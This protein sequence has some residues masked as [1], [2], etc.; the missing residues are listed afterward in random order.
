MTLAIPDIYVNICEQLLYWSDLIWS[1]GNSSSQI[2]K[3]LNLYTAGDEE[4]IP[5]N[6]IK[7]VQKHLS[8]Q[9]KSE[10]A[11]TTLLMDTK[12]AFAFT[13]PYIPTDVKLQSVTIPPILVKK[14]LATALKKIWFQLW[15]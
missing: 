15:Y 14:G 4:R 11:T 13:I 9:R 10:R 5:P 7:A 3:I 6:F 1:F 12:Y 2:I 8:E